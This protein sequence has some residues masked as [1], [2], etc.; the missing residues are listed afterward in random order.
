MPT[1]QYR[2]RARDADATI[3]PCR[4]TGCFLQREQRGDAGFIL[5]RHR[6]HDREVSAPATA[7][8][9]GRVVRRPLRT[10][11]SSLS[12]LSSTRS[13]RLT[14]TYPVFSYFEESGDADF[15]LAFRELLATSLSSSN[16]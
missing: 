15:I 12:T 8:G 9:L 6:T 14:R 13:R 5:L 7:E 11:R 3:S 1:A 16:G 10:V 4:I 2:G